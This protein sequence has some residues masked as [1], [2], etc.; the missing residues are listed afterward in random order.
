MSKSKF[1]LN[2]SGVR[3]LLQSEAMQGVLMQYGNQIRQRVGDGYSVGKYVGK[4]RANVSVKAESKE[5]VRQ[6]LN[7]NALLKAMR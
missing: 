6:C 5:A 3:E 2:R 7:H 1:V 4:R